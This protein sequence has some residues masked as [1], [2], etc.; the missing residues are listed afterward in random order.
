MI[1][2]QRLEA[3]IWR[4]VGEVAADLAPQARGTSLEYDDL[5]GVG[6][7]RVAEAL[8]TS[9]AE[10]QATHIARHARFAMRDVIAR[11]RREA[12]RVESHALAY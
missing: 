1:P 2:E 12:N 5:V 10:P 7:M 9:K 6:W 4:I 3:E 8:A 11:E